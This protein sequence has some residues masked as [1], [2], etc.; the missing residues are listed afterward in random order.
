LG[1]CKVQN[2]NYQQSSIVEYFKNINQKE[3]K[4]EIFHLVIIDFID[5]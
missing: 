3:S 4:F 5:V 1:C 2:M